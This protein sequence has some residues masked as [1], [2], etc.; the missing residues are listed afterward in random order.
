MKKKVFFILTIL[1]VLS[2]FFVNAADADVKAK[3]T[4]C[5]TS[6]FLQMDVTHFQQ[7]KKFSHFLQL[8]IVNPNCRM[9][10]TATNVGLTRMFS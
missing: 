9:I 4:S 2:L 10:Q 3:A 5:L 1:L 6:R 8:V 7:K